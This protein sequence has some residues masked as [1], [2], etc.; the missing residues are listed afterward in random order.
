MNKF[1]LLVLGFACISFSTGCSSKETTSINYTFIEKITKEPTCE[2]EGVKS[3]ICNEDSSKNYNEVIPALGHNYDYEHATFTWEEDESCTAYVS[4]LRCGK[5]IEFETTVK[6]EILKEATCQQ[7]GDVILIASF[8]VDEKEYKNEKHII[9]KAPHTP[10]LDK[11]KS[12]PATYATEGKNVYVCSYCHEVI[13]EEKSLPQKEDNKSNYGSEENP[14]L[15]SNLNDWEAFAKDAALD[16]FANKYIKLTANIGDEAN[17]VTTSADAPYTAPFAG[18]FDGDNHEMYIDISEVGGGRTGLFAHA[19]D[20]ASFKN[21]IIKG[22]VTTDDSVAG[23]LVSTLV[24]DA[25][26][27]NIKNYASVTAKDTAGGIV[28]YIYPKITNKSIIDNVENYGNI[29]V[30][31]NILGGIVAKAE[32]KQTISNASNYANINYT[33]ETYTKDTQ[34]YIGGIVGYN[35]SGSVTDCRNYASITSTNIYAQKIGGIV[36]RNGAGSVTNCIYGY[37][38]EEVSLGKVQPTFSVKSNFCGGIIGSVDEKATISNCINYVNLVNDQ[39]GK[40]CLGGIA[41]LSNC[42]GITFTSCSNNGNITGTMSIGGIVGRAT[43]TVSFTSCT[44]T[45]VVKIGD[46]VAST[47][48]GAQNASTTAKKIIPG[49]IIGNI[50]KGTLTIE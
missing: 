47:D 6:K 9:G 4:C 33:G 17:K 8:T 30:T 28:G 40:S 2:N 25:T 26:I 29:S 10:V 16:P 15:I 43:N 38:A 31:N 5:E 22:S 49:N 46:T 27:T 14:F 7:D 45:G 32:G 11:S 21:L 48:C 42:A 39:E 13:N 44:N 18:H 23:G 50:A 3:F 41:G 35:T 12:I 1:K 24:S 20:N 19:G 36:G 37:T 34:T